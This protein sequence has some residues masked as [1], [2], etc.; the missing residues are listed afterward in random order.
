M[1]FKETIQ[2][3]WF[4]VGIFFLF[5]ILSLIGYAYPFLSNIFC[6]LIIALAF[7]FSLIKIEYGFLFLFFE[8]FF[9]L[10]GH[11]FEFFGISLRFGLFAVL[12]AVWLV[13]KHQEKQLLKSLK[14]FLDSGIGAVL[15]ILLFIVFLGFLQG[16]LKQEATLAIKDFINYSYFLLIFPLLEI[17]KNKF[18]IKISLKLSQGFIIGISI[19]TI[20]IFILFS[21]GL[22]QVHNWF[23]WWWRGVAIGKATD[24]G[25]N[26]FRIMSPA[27]LLVLPLFLVLLS[28]LIEQKKKLNEK[29]KR[30]LIFLSFLSGLVLIINFSRAYFLGIFLSLFVLLKGINWKRWLKFSSLTVFSLFLGF[31]ILFSV[32]SG[33]KFFQAFDF[34]QNRMKTVVDPETE[35]SSLTRMSILPNLIKEIK[36]DLLF[37][38]GLGSTISYYNQTT[39]QTETTYHLDWGYLEIW[40]ELG[41]FGLITYVL[42]LFYFFYFS[43]Q[44]LKEFENNYFQKRLIIGL[45]AGLFSLMVANLTAP[46]LFHSLGIFY[47]IFSFCL[48]FNLSKDETKIDYP[49]CYLE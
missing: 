18:F 24:A 43:W 42:L 21:S 14:K 4:V 27:H 30:F 46:V 9:G 5:Q 13:K 41:L 15:F 8:F 34:F 39:M 40:R 33:G 22:A 47:L 7:I 37:G 49:N 45:N 1:K 12:M 11:L 48:I 19:L 23:Y 35:V 44:R 16:L 10:Q 38:Q 2:K 25:G 29:T 17:F 36:I 26:F 6:I 3:I 32:I 31:I 28:F 20:I